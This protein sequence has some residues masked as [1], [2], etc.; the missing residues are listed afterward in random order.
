M[1]NQAVDR[2]K[3]LFADLATV[4]YKS[5]MAELHKSGVNCET[6]T[7]VPGLLSKISE[8]EFNICVINL[9][10][11]GIGPFEL[12]ENVRKTSRNVNLKIVVVTRQVHKLNIQN[13]MRAGA[14]DFIAEPFETLNLHNRILYHLRPVQVIKADRIEQ[15]VPGIENSKYVKLLLEATELLGRTDREHI[16]DSILKILQD[17]ATLLESNRT[18]L[19]I[20]DELANNGVV[21]ATSDDPK[22]SNFPISLEK[23]PEVVHVMHTGSLIFIEDVSQN[24]LTDAIS[25]TVKTISIGS[26]MVFPVRYH[27]EIVGVLIIRRP[28]ATELPSQDVMRVLQ[29]AANVMAAHANVAVLLRK[30]YKEFKKDVKAA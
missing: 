26:I 28:V 10:L 3:V 20:V 2:G 1:G 19:I 14:D 5:V 4:K 17:V 30:I 13:T 16:H 18:S 8:E 27:G 9:L 7:D 15:T 22:F 6:V 21:L 24:T 11:G 12:I 25:K 29:A 23:Y